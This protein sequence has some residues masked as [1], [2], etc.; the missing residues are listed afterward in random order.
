MSV[1][2]VNRHGRFEVVVLSRLQVTRHILTTFKR[3]HETNMGKIGESRSVNNI[4]KNVV[5]YHRVI[6]Q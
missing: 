3:C 2:H 6:A 1:L 5:S 4:R